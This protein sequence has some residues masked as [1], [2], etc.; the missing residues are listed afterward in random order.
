MSSGLR[1]RLTRTFGSRLALWYFVLFVASSVLVLGLAYALL[2]ASLQARDQDLVESTLI[3]YAAAFERRGLT[4]LNAAIAA[5]RS[6]G[7]YE[8]L[9]VRILT[10]G[11]GTATFFSMPAGWSDFDVER[12]S[13]PSLLGE[14][15]W[16][17][18][19]AV[20]SDERLEVLSAFLSGGVLFQVGKS[21]GPR[22]DLL[23]RFRG[24]ALILLGV[25][26]LAALAGGA[27]LTWSGLRPLRAMTRAVG[28]ILE[29]GTVRARVPVTHSGDPLDDAG[30]LMNRMLDRI[31]TLIA[32][33]RGSLDNVA[34]DLRTPLARLRA[35]AETALTSERTPDEYRHALADCLEEAERVI[36][37]LD[38]LM[39]LAEAE[40]GVVRLRAERTD[41][42]ALLRSVVDLYDDVA[43]D[44]GVA[45]RM[46][47]PEELTGTVDPVRMRQAV[48]NLV[49]NALKYTRAGGHVT[50]RAAAAPEGTVIEVT[51]TGGGISPADL[52]RIW[53]R[54]YRGDRSRS[55]RGLGLGLT[56]VKSIVEAHG[57]RVDVE[58]SPGQGARFTIRLGPADS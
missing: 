50:I 12:L 26:V 9:F 6:T 7:G 34:H 33:L 52:P 24:T 10:P 11:G 3:R 39:D 8:P 44:K 56:L 46:D 23:A 1:E 57:G 35:T 16:A 14:R 43:E 30:V 54:L 40:T 51:D 45:L 58:S 20:G 21:T 17:V 4:G 5:D 18:V 38:A 19:S 22:D 55:E 53:D 48:A 29:T 41:L 25:V 42:V 28:S 32:S 36:V 47:A 15:R 13:A 49:D 2:G 27:T 31:E 37:I